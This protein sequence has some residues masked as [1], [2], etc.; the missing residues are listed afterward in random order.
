MATAG[1]LHQGRAC[2]VA[3][4]LTSCRSG[5]RARAQPLLARVSRWEGSMPRYTVG[6]L[7]RVDAIE[8]ALARWPALIACGAS[9]RGIG[10]P[11]CVSQGQAAAGRM[12]ERLGAVAA[13][14]APSTPAPGATPA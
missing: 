1:A 3:D 13:E 4:R 10:L 5:G 14:P 11:D 7:E 6:H 12:L 9:Y 2:V 8:R